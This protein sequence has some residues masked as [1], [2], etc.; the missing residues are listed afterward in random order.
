M[1]LL[2]GRTEKRQW[3]PEPIIPPFP[4]TNAFGMTGAA[5]DPNAAMYVPAVWGC[6][7][8][9]ANALSQMDLKTYRQVSGRNVLLTNSSLVAEP[10]DGIPQS[11]WVHQAVTSMC[12]RGNLYALKDVPTG[13]P[14]ALQILNP[15]H[16]RYDALTD[17][18]M[19]I[20]N[21]GTQ[22][23]ITARMFHI[24]GM[25]LPGARIGLSPI[26]FAAKSIGIDLSSRKFAQDFFDNGG[27]PK[28][29]LTSDQDIDQGQARIAKQRLQE[30]TINREPAVFGRGLTYKNITVTAE[31]SQFL[32]TQRA[33]VA[34]IARYFNIPAE[35]VG[36]QTGSSLTYSTV[37]QNS[38][39]FLT[40]AVSFWMRR[41]ED[42]FSQLL[43]NR[44]IVRFD[45]TNL[46]RTDAKSEAEVRA[47]YIDAKVL[48]PSRILADM[49]QDPL[50]DDEKAELALIPNSITA[51]GAPKAGTAKPAD[52][53]TEG[54]NPNG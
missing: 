40:Y 37:E 23:D 41:I 4:G 19:L 14:N 1:G 32:A 3:T 7:S 13:V 53:A 25:T 47:I 16:V 39:N 9:L 50:T 26:S 52:P 21:D 36:G 30:S 44:Q 42:A 24:P 43:P 48:P 29:V 51:L 28:A 27:T 33:T 6:I 12:L 18:F 49:G 54:D 35:M 5:T 20:Q 46:L 38:L 10:S 31:E 22:T 17:T 15:D 11:I 8:L 2:T 45:P 34:D